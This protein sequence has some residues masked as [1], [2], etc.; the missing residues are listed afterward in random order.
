MEVNTINKITPQQLKIKN[1]LQLFFLF[2]M[3]PT[4]AQSNFP[5][6]LQGTWKIE[7]LY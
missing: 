4:F 6:F 7:K 1:I 5:Y 2:V 3:L